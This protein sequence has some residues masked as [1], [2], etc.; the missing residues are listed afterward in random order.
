M[1]PKMETILAVVF[2]RQFTLQTSLGFSDS[3]PAFID[4]PF[5]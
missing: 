2:A 3:E 1:A 5:G 4:A